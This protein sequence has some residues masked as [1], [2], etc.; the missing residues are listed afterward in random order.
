MRHGLFANCSSA[1]GRFAARQLVAPEAAKRAQQA[2][3]KQRTGTA[4]ASGSE[5]ARHRKQRMK[6]LQSRSLACS[7]SRHRLSR[8]KP[9][10]IRPSVL[11]S[12]CGARGA[13][14]RGPEPADVQLYW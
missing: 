7:E 10:S 4:T 6:E 13:A 1:S 5:A 9:A 3:A 12:C 8:L 2:A 14:A 11:Q